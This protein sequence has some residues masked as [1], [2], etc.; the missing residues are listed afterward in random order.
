M[1]GEPRAFQKEKVYREHQEVD[2]LTEGTGG[3][4]PPTQ[5]R[6]VTCL[7]ISRVAAGGGLG[8]SRAGSEVGTSEPEL[9]AFL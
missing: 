9:A 1:R 2:Q 7:S 6:P 4:C 3:T 5:T 8:S